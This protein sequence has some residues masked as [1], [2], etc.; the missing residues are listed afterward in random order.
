MVD[1]P[2]EDP[3]PTS[4]ELTAPVTEEEPQSLSVVSTIQGYC[5]HVDAFG[6]KGWIMD[7]NRPGERVEVEIVDEHGAIVARGIADIF[8]K[9]LLDAGIGDGKHGFEIPLP[10]SLSD[11]EI[12]RLRLM[13]AE[14]GYH[15]SGGEKIVQST[16]DF[17]GAIEGLDGRFL[18]GWV[19]NR[20]SPSTPVEVVLSEAGQLITKGQTNPALQEGG[21]RFRLALPDKYLNGRPHVF[22]VREA[23]SGRVIDG[24][25]LITPTF[26]TPVETIQRHVPQA[27]K[28]ALSPA[29]AYR[30]ESLT[31][32]L[33]AMHD[34]SLGASMEQRLNMLQTIHQQLVIGF[35]G[36]KPGSTYPPLAF[37]EIQSPRVSIVIPVHNKFEVTYHCL[38]SLLLAPNRTSF[39]VIVVDDGSEAE[40][41]D[42]LDLITGITCLH[43]DTAQGFVRSS[44]RGGRHARGEFVVMLNND[45]EVT[46]GWLD[47]LLEVFERFDLVGLA[48]GK[49]L[50]ADGRLQEAGGIVWGNGQPWN[51]G[52]NGNAADPKYNYVRQVDYISGACIMLPKTLWDELGGFDDYYVPAYYED[53]DIAFRVR[54]KGYKTVYTP[55]SQVF[56]FE[57]LSSGTSVASGMKRYQ[58]VN[59]PKFKG[60]WA[61]AY[62]FNGPAGKEP[63][64]AKDRNVT[65][66]VLMLDAETP[67][68]DRDAGSYAAIQ[69]M[70]L[71]QSLGFKVTFVP[72]NAAYLG[73][74]T[75]CL[76]RMGVECLYAPFVMSP[77]DVLQR[78]GREFDMVYITRHYVASRV[79]DAVRMHAPDAKIVLNNADLHFLRELRASIARNDRHALDEALRTREE[80]LGVMRKVDLVLSYNEV[81]HAVILSH[82]LDS[83]QVALCPWVVNV[84]EGIPGYHDRSDIAF[85]GGYGHPP[86]VEAVR[87]FVQEIMPLLRERLPGVRF[88]VYGSNP[89]DTFKQIETRDVVVKGYVESVEDV[90]KTCRVFVTP[91]LSGAGI[92]GKVVG[93]LAHGV[94]CVISPVAAEGIGVRDG[95]E[96]VIADTPQAWVEGIASL[97]EDRSRWQ[98]LSDAGRVFAEK[99]YS[100]AKGKKVMKAALENVG[101][102]VLEDNATLVS[103]Y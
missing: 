37:P 48:G 16:G 61:S 35:S 3:Y 80:E 66:R 94:P 52:R 73:S 74:Y 99:E 78:R 95:L 41:L 57:G 5:D 40:S 77:V 47:A 23:H 53:T 81:E 38:A 20:R 91:L 11:G 103:A 62:R 8:R 87:Y 29:A 18:T 21:N 56:H 86:N 102:F 34:F 45:T 96:A 90:Y 22:I 2:S 31:L 44:N 67:Q 24:T 1:L 9:D 64:L 97:Y 17:V 43:N 42:K 88:L 69:E 79:V 71:L 92:K 13:A 50:Y 6:A 14:S 7:Q 60:R 36:R 85:L 63:D 93:A 46:A 4:T 84:P 101:I 100:F 59:E 58:K 32:Q 39:E 27:I 49:L 83:T 28:A 15:L 76:Q 75:E 25:A 19:T 98:A 30:Y 55:F 54:E 68:P 72:Q 82:N 33:D 12:H 65:F 89:P 10:E 70:R 51:Y 26:Q